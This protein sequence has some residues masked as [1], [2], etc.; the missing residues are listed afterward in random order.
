MDR[1][2]TKTDRSVEKIYE[3]ADQEKDLKTRWKAEE[4]LKDRGY[5]RGFMG[6]WTKVENEESQYTEP[7]HQTL[8]DDQVSFRFKVIIF[9][10]CA[11]VISYSAHSMY[12][13]M[14]IEPYK[15]I[16]NGIEISLKS[17][18]KNTLIMAVPLFLLTFW[19]PL[20][21]NI[22]AYIG[23]ILS[24]GLYIYFATTKYSIM[25]EFTITS[26]LVFASSVILFIPK[27]NHNFKAILFIAVSLVG[28]LLTLNQLALVW[29]VMLS[30]SL[31]FFFKS[32]K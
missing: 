18:A 22:A 3:K 24:I 6:Q 5:K 29:T 13:F 1:F 32:E 27:I 7:R 9:V 2:I 19:S 31:M 21:R 25:G 16:N 8:N 26:L 17:I 12:T 4:T 10:V 15:L 11:L 14:Y 30:S 28:I 23:I 20:I